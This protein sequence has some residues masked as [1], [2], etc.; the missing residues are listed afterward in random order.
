MIMI[1][2]V[3]PLRGKPVDHGIGACKTYTPRVDPKED[4]DNRQS[5]ILVFVLDGFTGIKKLI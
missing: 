1:F 2:F 5:E 3:P 4:P